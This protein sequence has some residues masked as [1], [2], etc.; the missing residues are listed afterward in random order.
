MPW[1]QQETSSFKFLSYSLAAFDFPGAVAEMLSVTDLALLQPPPDLALL[2]RETDQHPPHYGQF[3]SCFGR[4]RDMFDSF[5][6]EVAPLVLS[7]AYCYQPIP[8]LRMH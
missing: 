1:T 8:T 6:S 7:E 5:V 3:Y 4:L 2:T